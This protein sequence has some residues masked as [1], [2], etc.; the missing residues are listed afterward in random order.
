MMEESNDIFVAGGDAL[1]YLAGPMHKKYSTT[2]IWGHPFSTYISYDQFF[3]LPPTCTHM[4]AF[5]VTLLLR[6]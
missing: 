2:F 6:M 3:K 4:Y 1:V 5:R